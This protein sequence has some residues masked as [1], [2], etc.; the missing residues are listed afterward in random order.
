[1]DEAATAEG[2]LLRDAADEADADPEPPPPPPVGLL[3]EAPADAGPEELELDEDD[4]AELETAGGVN[5][6]LLSEPELSRAGEDF[7]L[8][9]RLLA[10]LPLCCC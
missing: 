4:E 5:C 1:M 2:A 8:A 3:K 6:P 10:P 9:G 7:F